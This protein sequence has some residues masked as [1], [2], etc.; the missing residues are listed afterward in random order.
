MIYFEA[1]FIRLEAPPDKGYLMAQ[2]GQSFSHEEFLAANEALLAVLKETGRTLLLSDSRYFP[3]PSHE[4]LDYILNEGMKVL[5]EAGLEKIAGVYP[6][7][8]FSQLAADQLLQNKN[9]FEPLQFHFFDSFEKAEQCLT[10]EL[11]P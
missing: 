5:A 10:E 4:S 3:P 6:I 11:A 9:L 7:D 2:W 1:S 8:S